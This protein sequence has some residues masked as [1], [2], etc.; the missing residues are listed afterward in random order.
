MG[1]GRLAVPEE[2]VVAMKEHIRPVKQ[3]NSV[4]S[5]EELATTECS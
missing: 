3:R 2:R 1:D 5:W 4:H